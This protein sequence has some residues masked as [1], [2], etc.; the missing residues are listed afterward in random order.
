[1]QDEPT[2]EEL[3]K[4]VADFLRSDIAPQISGHQAFKLRVA[5]NALDLVTRQITLEQDSDAAEIARLSQLLA[6]QG[7]L[8]ELNRAL[9]IICPSVLFPYARAAVSQ[10]VTQGGFPQFLLPPVNFEALHSRS[11]ANGSVAT[12]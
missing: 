11:D 9:A 7:S 12:N 4:A 3:I 2:P 5:I 8:G 6:M 10:L 1:M